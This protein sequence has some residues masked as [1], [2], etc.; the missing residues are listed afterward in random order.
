M[1]KSDGEWL[2]EKKLKDIIL[3]LKNKIKESDKKRRKMR[4]KT[5]KDGRK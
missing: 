5:S 3:G 2:V 1:Q 4:F